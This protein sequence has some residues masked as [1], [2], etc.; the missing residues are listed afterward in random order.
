MRAQELAFGRGPAGLARRGVPAEQPRPRRPAFP[1]GL[2]RRPAPR[3]RRAVGVRGGRPDSHRRLRRRRWPRQRRAARGRGV[4]PVGHR[5]VRLRALDVAG[6]PPAL[7]CPRRCYVR[8]AR[9]WPPALG[10]ASTCSGR[11]W[12]Q[13]VAVAAVESWAMRLLGRLPAENIPLRPPRPGAA[14]CRAFPDRRRCP[15]RSRH[16]GV[17]PDLGTQCRSRARADWP[18][19]GNVC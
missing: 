4:S 5:R 6:G 13:G 19:P 18:A 11:R 17:L 3:G 9:L 12:R 2:G 8:D 16:P 14:L 15:A 1:R 7:G 10:R